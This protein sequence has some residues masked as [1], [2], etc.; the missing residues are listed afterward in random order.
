MPGTGPFLFLSKHG[1][2]A[3]FWELPPGGMCVSAFLFVRR[4]SGILLG[5]YK[6]DPKWE[7]LAGLD[8]ARR[9][10][11]SA[12]W[13]IPARQLKFGEDPREAAHEIAEDIL[14][15]HRM[16]TKG[17]RVEVDVYEPRQAPGQLHYDI[18]FLFE[19]TPPKGWT[20]AVPPW[21]AELAWH[22]PKKL[23]A[24]EYA[25]GHQDVAARWLQRPARA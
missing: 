16:T 22:D 17:P 11:H 15:I 5:K 4:G 18:W 25:R 1:P 19:G 20:L 10:M 3:G 8:G 21:Y 13:T 12:G 23:P 14:D 7:D 2:P 6:D 9:R 24:A